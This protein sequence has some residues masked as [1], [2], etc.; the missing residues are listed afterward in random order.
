MFR[1]RDVSGGSGTMMI[2][3]FGILGIYFFTSLYL[4]Q[5]LASHRSRP[6]WPSCRWRCC[7]AVFAASPAD[8]GAAGAHRTVA[9]GMLLMVVGLV[10]SPGS[11]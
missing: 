1:S 10:C 11:A 6:A 4:Q 5:T 9:A 3:A 2:W 7:V 8:R